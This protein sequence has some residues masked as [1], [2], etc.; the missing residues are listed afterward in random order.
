MRGCGGRRRGL[1]GRALYG[2][3]WARTRVYISR[4]PGRTACGAVRAMEGAPV[5]GAMQATGAG[6]QRARPTKGMVIA[7]LE[8]AVLTLVGCATTH[9]LQEALLSATTGAITM[10]WVTESTAWLGGVTLALQAVAAGWR[11]SDGIGTTLHLSIASAC[12]S[13]L[14]CVLVV[15]TV[16]ISHAWRSPWWLAS[17][18]PTTRLGREVLNGTRGNNGTRPW[19]AVFRV[20]D[21]ADWSQAALG[22]GTWEPDADGLYMARPGGF[23]SQMGMILAGASSGHALLLLMVSCYAAFVSAPS[24]AW[25]PLFADPT[26]MFCTNCV[27]SLAFDAGV[28]QGFARCHPGGGYM[29]GLV[30]LALLGCFTQPGVTAMLERFP[31]QDNLSWDVWRYTSLVV[32]PGIHAMPL[33]F[34]ALQRLS[35]PYVLLTSLALSVLGSVGAVYTEWGRRPPAPATGSAQVADNKVQPMNA[36][37]PWHKALPSMGYDH[38]QIPTL[39]TKIC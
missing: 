27:L 21:R 18:E 15:H 11:K 36:E 17:T 24:G 30:V 2:G 35:S 38:G 14:F 12:V 6:A 5:E 10:A 29:A 19:A 20:D 28:Q 16:M 7:T 1:P 9:Y 34:G 26:T 22:G 33:V 37:Y 39:R 31:S 23:S 8:A 3:G 32:M 4:A 13:A 25:V